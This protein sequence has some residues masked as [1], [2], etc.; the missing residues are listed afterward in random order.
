MAVWFAGS[1]VTPPM[2]VRLPSI[3][4]EPGRRQV[5]ATQESTRDGTQRYIRKPGNR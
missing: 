3:R 1:R 4:R 2:S 5:L